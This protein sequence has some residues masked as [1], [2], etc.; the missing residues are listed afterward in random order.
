[1]NFEK[2]PYFTR[3]FKDVSEA[4]CLYDFCISR[5][6]QL[7]LEIGRR[8]GVSTRLFATA[9]SKWD[10]RVIS[11]DGAPRDY[12]PKVLDEMGLTYFVDLID[13]WSPWIVLDPAWVI[14][15]LY[16]DGDHTYIATLA[17]YHYFNFF[18]PTGGLIVF[19]DCLHKPVTQAITTARQ[20]D[21]LRHLETVGNLAVFEKT[22]KARRVYHQFANVE[23]ET[24]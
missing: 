20:R 3:G 15:L 18:V 23:F 1:M 7:I 22:D 12:V 11:I 13:Q 19:H 6:P 8:F 21:S 14:D 24:I 10:G 17:D 5:R 2:W 9:V 4:R 16:I